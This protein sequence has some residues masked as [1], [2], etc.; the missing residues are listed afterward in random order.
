MFQS[1][2]R[3]MKDRK[4]SVTVSREAMWSRSVFGNHPEVRRTVG[5]HGR[6]TRSLRRPVRVRCSA[7]WRS[8]SASRSSGLAEKAYSKPGR[9]RRNASS[10]AI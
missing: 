6:K 5:V 4:V 3:G 2:V 7:L 10:H 9:P 8:K 1:E